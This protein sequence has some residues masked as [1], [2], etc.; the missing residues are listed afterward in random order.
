MDPSSFDPSA[1][2]QYPI[3]GIVVGLVV[4]MMH[5]F[6][7]ERKEMGDRFEAM[8]ANQTKSLDDN[9]KAIQQLT[10][11]NRDVKNVVKELRSD[12]RRDKPA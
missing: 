5:F 1:F 11:T 12:I 9:T 7:G 4:W 2:A 3:V 8:H 10:M 6:R